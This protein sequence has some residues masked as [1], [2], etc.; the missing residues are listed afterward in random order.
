MVERPRV[1]KRGNPTF[2]NVVSNERPISNDETTSLTFR[3]NEPNAKRKRRTFPIDSSDVG[4]GKSQKKPKKKPKTKTGRRIGR[5]KNDFFFIEASQFPLCFDMINMWWL[6]WL[7]LISGLSL[8]NGDSP[9]L[10]L[11]LIGRRGTFPRFCFPSAAVGVERSATPTPTSRRAHVQ[12]PSAG[13]VIDDQKEEGAGG[14]LR[15]KRRLRRSTENVSDDERAAS[16]L[17]PPR[18]NFPPRMGRRR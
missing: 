4:P 9:G 16:E 2:R 7:V 1:T 18:R 12:L 13:V 8:A 17:L 10:D 5:R 14:G 11:A 15:V 3:R 6:V